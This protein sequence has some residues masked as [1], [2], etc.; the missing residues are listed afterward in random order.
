MNNM[1]HFRESKILTA[2]SSRS[3]YLKPIDL[4]DLKY[5]ELFSSSEKLNILLKK[6]FENL[7]DE[8]K[9]FVSNYPLCSGNVIMIKDKK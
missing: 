6:G 1:L 3:V 8:E 7:S 5:K 9:Q 2:S 4:I